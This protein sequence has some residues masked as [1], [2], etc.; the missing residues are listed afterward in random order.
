MVLPLV[1][2]TVYYLSF[3]SE[4]AFGQVGHE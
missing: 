1:V 4:M 2:V 3:Y